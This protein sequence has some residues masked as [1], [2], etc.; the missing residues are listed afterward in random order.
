M[1]Q[2]SGEL[3]EIYLENGLTGGRL[4]CPPNLVPLPGQ[5]LLAHDPASSAP[6]PA[7]VFS[8]GSVPGGFL[9][10][11]PI[12]LAWRPGLSLSLRGPLGHGFSLP[13]S[14]R[15]V[16]L[17]ALGETAARL[18]PLLTIA[19]GQGAAVVLVSD[20]GL[21]D[22]PPEVEHQPVAALPEVM[23][24]SD[25]MALDLPWES[26][27]GVRE[28]MGV[29][30]QA[31]AKFEAQAL[32]ITPMPCG[33]MAECGVCAVNTRHGWKL[34]CKDGPVFDLKELA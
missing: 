30:G 26:L 7:P 12:P 19:L 20:L 16:S 18:H 5:Y 1:Q 14:T 27:P 2:A 29:A 11:P 31:G 13:E 9:A 28:K 4:Y 21:T 22:L 24:W 32:I 33:G 10:A 23:K 6:L 17:V 8:A 3:V 25:Y 15:C 34:A